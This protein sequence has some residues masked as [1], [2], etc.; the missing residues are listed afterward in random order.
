M[1]THV[2]PI[3]LI[4]NADDYGYF[5]CVSRGIVEL[6]AA[7]KLTAT[8]IMANS[9]ELTHQLDNLKLVPGLDIG[10][11]LNLTYGQPLT[12]Q[13]TGKLSSYGGLF[14][15]AY[16]MSVLILTGQIG[17]K[18]VRAEWQ[19]QIEACQDKHLLFLNSHEHIHMLPALFKLTLEL[20]EE[21][22]IPHVR[23]TSAEWLAPIGLAGLVRNTVMQCLQI[24]NRNKLNVQTHTLLGLSQSGKLSIE[25]LTRIFATLKPGQT[26]ELMCHPGYCESEDISDLRLKKYHDW[27]GELDVLHSP[28]LQNVYER[29]GILLCH[30]KQ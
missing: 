26:Y 18:E 3:Q 22:R 21:Y 29:F 15:S 7:G 1:A 28:Q 17:I 12:S 23:L 5:P 10:V 30:Y 11:H 8:G 13:M 6:A 16:V 4:V 19:A 2:K 14:P 20:A 25:S 9:P 27:K 24:I